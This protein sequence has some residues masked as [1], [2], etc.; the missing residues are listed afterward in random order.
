MSAVYKLD[1]GLWIVFL[2]CL[3][4]C[5]DEDL[6]VLTPHG[7]GRRLVFAEVLLELWIGCH[8]I[9]VIVEDVQL[10]LCVARTV[11]KVGVD[12][13]RFWRYGLRVCLAVD[14][15]RSMSEIN[16]YAMRTIKTCLP[17][18]TVKAGKEADTLAGLL[19][20]LLPVSLHRSPRLA[21][22]VLVRV[23]ILADDRSY[24]LWSL[25]SEP[26]EQYQSEINKVICAQ[27][28]LTSDQ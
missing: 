13:I 6:I 26:G 2:E 12:M 16:S 15:L 22:A 24:A 19:G 8:I 28:M 20:S 14:V 4:T 17:F 7:K 9:S 21:Q 25:Q 27:T 1:H 10:Y 3:R 23:T 18:D 5:G 11:N